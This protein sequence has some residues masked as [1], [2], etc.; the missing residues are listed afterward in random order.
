V[1][2]RNDLHGLILYAAKD[3]VQ[4]SAVPSLDFIAVLIDYYKR[5]LVGNAIFVRK[6]F[7]VFIGVGVIIVNADNLCVSGYF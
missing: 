1:E 2:Y 6:A 5:M 3:L 4:A 7:L